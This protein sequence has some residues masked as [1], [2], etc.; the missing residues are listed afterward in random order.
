[1]SREAHLKIAIAVALAVL[2]L[3]VYQSFAQEPTKRDALFWCKQQR[4]FFADNAIVN[5]E[6]AALLQDENEKLKKEIEELKKK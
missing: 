6:Q 2:L 1:V 5:A 4:N 3:F